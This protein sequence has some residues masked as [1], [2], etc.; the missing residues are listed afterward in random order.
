MTRSCFGSTCAG[1]VAV[2]DF[3][4]CNV[5]IHRA[6]TKAVEVVAQLD[7]RVNSKKLAAA[8]APDAPEQ[9]LT[10]KKLEKLSESGVLLGH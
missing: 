8:E 6:L 5:D 2:M 10:W 7:I 1:F 4:A 3:T 9:V